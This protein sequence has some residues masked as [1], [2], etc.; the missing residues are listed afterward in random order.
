MGLA[1]A[2]AILAS[3][4]WMTTIFAAA[5]AAAA[6]TILVLG[7]EPPDS[8]QTDDE[9][10]ARARAWLRRIETTAPEHHAKVAAAAIQEAPP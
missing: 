1:R 6:I 5:A 8:R 3:G 10:D 4:G 2:E 9:A 7:R